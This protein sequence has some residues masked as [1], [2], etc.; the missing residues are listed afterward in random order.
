MARTPLPIDLPLEPFFVLKWDR[1]LE[2]MILAVPAVPESS[3]DLGD[4]LPQVSHELQLRG[5]LREFADRAVDSARE[6]G[7]VQAIPSQDR[8]I[9]LFPRSK[10]EDVL[11]QLLTE[12]ERQEGSSYASL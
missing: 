7:S 9:N 2:T 8:I 12:A 6:F 1:D 11:S 10:G 5:L 4:A 3:F